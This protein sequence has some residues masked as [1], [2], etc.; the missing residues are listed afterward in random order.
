MRTSAH[1]PSSP[2]RTRG[3]STNC[4]N[5]SNSRPPPPTCSRSLAARPSIFKL[6]SIRWS[7]RR[8]CYVRPIRLEYSDRAGRTRA[9]YVQARTREPSTPNT[10]NIIGHSHLLRD[11]AAWS[12]EFYWKANP[13]IFR[14]FFLIRSTHWVKPQDGAAIAQASGYPST[15]GKS[16]WSAPSDIALSYGRSPTKRLSLRRRLPTRRS[17]RSRTCGCSTGAGPHARAFGVVRAADRDL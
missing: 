10:M 9:E 4:A 15:R 16:N 17:S 3:C 1:K 6:C 8:R 7:S 13:F 5:P 14:M 12:A 2:S 11:A